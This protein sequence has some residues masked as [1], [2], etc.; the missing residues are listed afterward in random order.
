MSCMDN[1]LP[2]VCLAGLSGAGKQAALAHLSRLGYFCTDS[3][4]PNLALDT[5]TELSSHYSQ[6]AIGLELSR[7]EFLAE[8][9]QLVVDLRDRSIALL[10][11]EADDDELIQQ[12]SA[13]R[14]RHPLHARTNSVIEAVQL[15]RQML[16]PVRLQCTHTLNTSTL[17][18]RQFQDCLEQIVLNREV[19]ALVVGLTSFGFKYGLPI[20]ANIVFDVRCLPNPYYIPEL[21]PLTGRDSPIRDFL[22]KNP[23]TQSTYQ[24]ILSTLNHFLPL[25]SA[26]RRPWVQVAIGCTGGQHRSVAIVEQL[27]RDLGQKLSAG[28]YDFR[29][30]H[31][32]LARSQAEIAARDAHLRSG[33]R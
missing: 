23:V 31:R 29:L 21:R 16:A 25:Y 17:S 24:Q 32:H 13:T 10:F 7:M 18:A 9:E 4:V 12:L 20:D 22:F 26:E 30:D 14:S 19:P 8:F 15:E 33:K 28:N 3:V 27:A 2:T 6:V 5:L 1:P 11:L